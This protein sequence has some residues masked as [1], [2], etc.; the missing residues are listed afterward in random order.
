MQ[1]LDLELWLSSS[2]KHSKL[3]D[4]FSLSLT[5]FDD[6]DVRPLPARAKP[7]SSDVHVSNV[8]FVSV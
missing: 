3:C 4:S 2:E 6:I 8:S 5:A 7:L 1:L